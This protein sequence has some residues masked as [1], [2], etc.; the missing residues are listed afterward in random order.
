M[1][2]IAP[3]L[4]KQIEADF[5]RLVEA[6]T[7]IA[8][9]LSAV[10]NSNATHADLQKYAEL[11]GECCSAAL[12]SA[13]TADV[14]PNGQM[15]YNIAERTIRPALESNRELVNATA[16]EIQSQL[17]RAAEI[18]IKAQIPQP[19]NDRITNLINRLTADPDFN[20]VQWIIDEPIV[21]FTL[22]V[23]DDFIKQNFEFQAKAGLNPQISRIT[24]GKCCDW[25]SNLAG[26][27]DYATVPED[28]YRRHAFCRCMVIYTPGDGRRQNV[29]T[30][31]W[32]DPQDIAELERRKTVGLNAADSFSA[33][34]YKQKIKDL[35]ILDYDAI[36]AAAKNGGKHS[37]RY[38]I[39]LDYGEVQLRKSIMS[40]YRQVEEHIN[41]IKY[42]ETL[43]GWNEISDRERTGIFSTWSSHLT[44]N[45]EEAAIE[46]SLWEEKFEHE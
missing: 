40:H 12:K 25:C 32:D 8:N 38:E 16:I 4:H 37:G 35:N 21:N 29:W 5:A 7:G 1:V 19:N 44:R 36:I 24:V 22:S 3:E 9:I 20:K 2:D 42:P 30:K 13:I 43:A 27:Y 45:A 46:I 26:V 14:L 28:F 15:Y 18:G 17:N 39:M 41:K 23:A 34:E 11:L 31:K 33:A 10:N 6:N